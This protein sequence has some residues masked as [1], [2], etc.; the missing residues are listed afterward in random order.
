MARYRNTLTPIGNVNDARAMI[1]KYLT[2]EGFKH[3]H[4]KGEQVW[5]KGIG[6]MMGPQFV[7]LTLQGAHLGLEALDPLCA[8]A[9]DLCR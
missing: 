5:K 8:V 3:L 4:Y 9:G 1:E 7:K 2:S 6:L